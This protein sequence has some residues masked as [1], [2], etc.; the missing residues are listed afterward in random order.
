MAEDTEDDLRAS[1]TEA[2]EN[3]EP[4]GLPEEGSAPDV[5]APDVP[6]PS[7]E[8]EDPRPRDAQGRFIKEDAPVDP[9]APE[10]A[11]EAQEATPEAPEAQGAE[12]APQEA[13]EDVIAPPEHWRGAGKIDWNRL[14]K[15]VK[16]EIS[17]DYKQVQEAQTKYRALDDVLEPRRQAL[18]MEHGSVE[19]ALG[20][21][22][23]LSDFASSNP[24]E[25]INWYAQQQG[26][27]L[28]GDGQPE[29]SDP[30]QSRIGNLEQTLNGLASQIQQSQS[31]VYEREVNAFSQDPNHPYF[32]DVRDHM[33]ALLGNG[34]A[35]DL[36]D[37][38]DQAVWANPTTRQSLLDAQREEQ[39]AERRQKAEKAKTAAASVSGAP[40][41]GVNQGDAPSDSIRGELLKQWSAA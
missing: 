24:R 31:S 21:L 16:E 7:A 10:A 1:L 34:Q 30:L 8:G 40:T 6:S 15:A 19:N 35:K 22:F 28:T 20:K 26:V 11:P 41:P 4:A 37:A 2:M 29:A 36:Q 14:P 23:A 33:A 39:E 32:N 17:S 38:Y 9:E 12:E 25:F 18:T 5:D 13:P 27:D 3:P